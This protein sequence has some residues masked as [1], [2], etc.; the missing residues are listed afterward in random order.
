MHIEDEN[1]SPREKDR[2]EWSINYRNALGEKGKG[3]VWHIDAKRKMVNVDVKKKVEL[4]GKIDS[5]FWMRMDWCGVL[6]KEGL[7]LVL[8]LFCKMLWS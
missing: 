1:S 4:A 8:R 6:F 5:E 2:Y 7:M 3:K